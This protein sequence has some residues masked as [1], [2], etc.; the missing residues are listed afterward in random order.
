[1][2]VVTLGTGW[3]MG[4]KM[5]VWARLYDGDRAHKLLTAALTHSKDDGYG[6]V[7][8]MHNGGG[9]YA[10]M[11]STHPPFQLDGNMGA[12]AGV[13]EMLMQSHGG[14]IKLLPALPKKWHTGQVKGLRARGGFEVSI[15]WKEGQL[16]S[17]TITAK[18]AGSTVLKYQG[19]EVTVKL[20]K[21][22][23]ITLDGKLK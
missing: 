11:L 6:R 19:K 4:W 2:L 13:A 22:E 21:G 14:V 8:D 18:V 17:T 7:R 20:N 5:N 12:A 1:M 16:I 3:A 23:S 15:D 10:N 9:V